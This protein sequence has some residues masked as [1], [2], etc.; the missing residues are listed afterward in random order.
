MSEK[1]GNQEEYRNM[2]IDIISKIENLEYLKSIYWL[3]K[4]LSE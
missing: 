3:S 4:K 1:S 2:I